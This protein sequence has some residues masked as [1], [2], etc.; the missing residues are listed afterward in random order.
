MK[1]ISSFLACFLSLLSGANAFIDVSR[2]LKLTSQLGDIVKRLESQAKDLFS[3]DATL[4]LEYL[5]MRQGVSSLRTLPEKPLATSKVLLA[6]RLL[7]E[8]NI[9]GAH[10]VIL[11]VDWS[12]LDEAEYAATHRGQTNWTQE[13]PFSEEDNLVHSLI[14]R[15]EGD[16]EGEGSYTG[17]ENAKYW[18][19]GGPQKHTCLGHGAIHQALC[20]SCSRICSPSLVD[21]LVTKKKRMHTI[22]A[23]GGTTRS[24]WIDK[25]CFDPVSFINL[26][27]HTE[28]NDELRELQVA[29]VL[30]LIRIELMRHFGEANVELV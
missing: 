23:G 25:G 3:S 20:R 27:Q 13:H 10:D 11:G 12:N 16:I 17:W 18:V 26:C 1:K 19:A 15:L 30:L 9:D 5:I 8:K 6:L 22:I 28:W 4:A 2:D 29:E 21:L 7:L 14:H 24:V